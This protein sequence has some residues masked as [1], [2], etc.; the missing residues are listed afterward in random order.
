MEFREI[1][2]TR[3]R[4]NACEPTYVRGRWLANLDKPLEF[5]RQ[6]GIFEM[7]RHFQILSRVWHLG[8]QVKAAYTTTPN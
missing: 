8:T 7:R 2:T 6:Q 5:R 3:D 4:G 1:N